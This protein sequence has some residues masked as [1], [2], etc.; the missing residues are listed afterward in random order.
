MCKNILGRRYSNRKAQRKKKKD[1]EIIEEQEESQY[2]VHSLTWVSS[3]RIKIITT[4]TIL[5]YFLFFNLGFLLNSYKTCLFCYLHSLH[6]IEFWNFELSYFPQ[7]VTFFLLNENEDIIL[8]IPQTNDCWSLLWFLSTL[9]SFIHL[10]SRFYGFLLW[11][12]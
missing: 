10:Q 1:L 5:K 4:L 9:I 6:N 7:W 11:V 3:M 8:Q 2:I 12:I